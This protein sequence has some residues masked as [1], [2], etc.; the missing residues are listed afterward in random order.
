MRR[1]IHWFWIAVALAFLLEAWLW[2]RLQPLIAALVARLPLE[3]AKQR[4]AIWV[5]D[6]SPAASMVVFALPVAVLLPFKFAGLW[7]LAQGYWAGA[8]GMLLCA[9]VVGLGVTAFVFSACR[10]KL[11]QLGWFRALHDRV[12]VWRAWA[13]TLV[14]PVIHEVRAQLALFAPQRAGRTMRLML[15]IRRRMHAPLGSVKPG[16]S[17]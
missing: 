2:D 16:L 5:K 8:V 11:M 4:I 15:R 9:K 3:W 7:L 14:D 17:S 13:H 1:I 10:A 6:L 12:I